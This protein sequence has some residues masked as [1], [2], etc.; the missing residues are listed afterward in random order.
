MRCNGTA[1]PDSPIC[2][3]TGS[4]IWRTSSAPSGEVTRG[5]S[6]IDSVVIEGLVARRTR[7]ARSPL[8]ALTPRE[9]DVLREKAQG[10]TN[11]GIEQA[12]HLPSST[13]VVRGA[14]WH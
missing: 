4:A 8:A 5:G 3:G 2:S 1:P 10:K 7:A 11:A 6:V 12:L 9:V 13:V 14:G